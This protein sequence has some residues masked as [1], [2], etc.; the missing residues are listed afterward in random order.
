MEKENKSY[1]EL[2]GELVEAKKE[3]TRLLS[4]QINEL[5][6]NF[7]A[8]VE[9]AQYND[10]FIEALRF[11]DKF[12]KYNI[13]NDALRNKALNTKYEELNYKQTTKPILNKI[14]KKNDGTKTIQ[15]SA[16]NYTD[17]ISNNIIGHYFSPIFTT[18]DST[19]DLKE[20]I[21]E[22]IS[23]ITNPKEEPKEEE[24]VKWEE[25]VGYVLE[26][27]DKFSKEVLYNVYKFLEELI[28]KDK[29]LTEWKDKL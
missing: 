12:G 28:K 18:Q 5:I 21:N 7:N 9:Y 13:S 22:K 24:K 26:H 16:S 2:L 14:D 11:L 4:Y 23:E 25:K 29:E 20:Y 27:K 3:E 17:T 15:I 1:N 19:Q 8:V 6:D 10:E